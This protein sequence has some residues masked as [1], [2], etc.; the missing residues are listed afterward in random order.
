VTARTTALWLLVFGAVAPLCR[1]QDEANDGVVLFERRSAL[2]SSFWGRDIAM[3]AGVVLPPDRKAGEALPV[4]YSIHGFGGSHRGAWRRGPELIEQM[5]SGYPRM[6][7]V[8]LNASCPLGHHEFADS[9][10]NGP[11]GT[12]LVT[13]FAPALEAEFA[14]GGAPTRRYLTGHSSGGWSSLWLQITHPDFFGGTWSTSPDSVDFRDFTG[15]DIYRFD[16]AYVDP[17]GVPI[18]LM[19]RNGEFVMSLQQFARREAAARPYGGQFAS[20]DAVFSPRGDD[21][22]PMPLFDRDTGAIDKAV[23]KA[24]ENYDIRLVLERNWATLGPKLRGKLHAFCGTQDTYR[25]EG[26]LYLLR[27]ALLQLGSDAQFVFAEGRDHSTV[28]RAHELWPDGL[29][30]RIHREMRAQF[31]AAADP[32]DR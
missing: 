32:S 13:E 14:A 25:L 19:R 4:C 7:Y 17:D 2:L 28:M 15:V 30:A 27:T 18:Q 21:G 6:L 24:W 12:A 3:Q 9:V 20:F 29:L 22:R 5:R 26:A 16:S 10:N 31:D 23:A 1:A 8:F 11:W